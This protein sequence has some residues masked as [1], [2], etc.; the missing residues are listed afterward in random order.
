MGKE[1]LQLARSMLSPCRLCPRECGAD[2]LGG[3]VGFCRTGRLAR[4]ASAGPHFGEEAVLVGPGGSGTIF[5]QCCNLDCVFCQNFNISHAAGGVEVSEAKL[6]ALMLD[7]A[8][9]G[10]SNVNLVTP[11]H[12]APQ[13]L[14]AILLARGRGMDVPV[15]YNCGGYE[16][17]EMLRL[18]EG[19]VDVYMPDYKYASSEASLKYSGVGDYPTAA[20]AAL[21]EMY[22]QVG[23]LALDGR[24]LARRG[25]MVRH[26]VMPMDLADSRK[27]IDTVAEAAPGAA[28]NVMD[29]YRPSYRASEFPELL[30]R[31]RRAEIDRLRA[32][33][34]SR[35]LMRVD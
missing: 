28:V 33:A 4:V 34:S 9:G 24:G 12:V 1:V 19:H 22:R 20:R 10:C 35:G 15:V 11:T 17:V 14:G 7:L 16:S 2:R 29:Q 31:P 8:G 18:L 5:F 21:A 13:I 3:E 6:A 32:Y 26:L 27:V 23:P 30:E 25:V